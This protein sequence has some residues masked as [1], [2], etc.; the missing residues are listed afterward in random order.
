MSVEEIAAKLSP[1]R[2]RLLLATRVG[3]TMNSDNREVKGLVSSG[4]WEDAG[5]RSPSLRALS[6][7]PLG[8]AV[9]DHLRG[10]P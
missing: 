2:Q 10:Q 8:L 5:Y 1:R 9:R 3:R 7:T 4:L 6:L